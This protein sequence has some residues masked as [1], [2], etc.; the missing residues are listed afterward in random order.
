MSSTALRSIVASSIIILASTGLASAHNEAKGPHG[1]EVVDSAGHHI[2]FV[3][4]PSE[5]EFYLSDEA[6]KPIDSA[7]TRA[8]ALIQDGGKTTP[9]DLTAAS[10]NKLIAKIAAPL[11]SG[12]KVVVTA[13]MTDGHSIAARYV[14]P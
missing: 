6:G 3:P 1:G 12:A 4:T 8:K 14:L 5:L 13:T 7:G 9:V 10:P 2:E 11:A